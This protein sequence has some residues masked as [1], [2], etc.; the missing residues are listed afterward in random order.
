MEHQITIDKENKVLKLKV[1]VPQR[2][3]EKEPKSTIRSAE[4]WE[5]AKN[6]KVEGY[7]VEY[8]KNN[9]QVDNWST[10]RLQ[11]EFIFPLRETKKA[12]APKPKPT[13]KTAAPKP[14]AFLEKKPKSKAKNEQKT[15]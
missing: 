4:A 2:K 3:L 11:G 7:A 8:K 6:T 14:K 10:N 13:K 12:P 1:S 15:E 9:L 5:L